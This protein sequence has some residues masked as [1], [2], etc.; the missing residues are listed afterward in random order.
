MVGAMVC[1]IVLSASFGDRQRG[2]S[3]QFSATPVIG[4]TVEQ[5]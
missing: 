4:P 1:A 3:S 2:A 5:C